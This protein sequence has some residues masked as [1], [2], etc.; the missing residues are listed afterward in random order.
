MRFYELKICDNTGAVTHAEFSSKKKGFSLSSY[1]PINLEFQINTF[2]DNLSVSLG[3][4][5]LYNID[6]S[7]FIKTQSLIGERILLRAGWDNSVFAKKLGWDNITDDVLLNMQIS[8]T[9]ADFS[10]T[11]PYLDIFFIP[12]TQA[13]N[14]PEAKQENEKE[15]EQI[16]QFV[17]E[18]KSGE[19]V[20][21]KIKATLS[22]IIDKGIK[23]VGVGSEI[24]KFINPST[25]TTVITANILSEFL[26]KINENFNDINCQFD[27]KNNCLYMYQGEDLGSVVDDE[28]ATKNAIKLKYNELI[29]QPSLISVAG[30][31][32]VETR[33]RP[34]INTG[35]RIF[36]EGNIPT[37]SSFKTGNTL[38]SNVDTKRIFK[39]G[40]Y[41]V[42]SVTH[43]GNFYGTSPQDWSSSFE[44]VP[45]KI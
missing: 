5:R 30:N 2:K 39:S 25:Q 27:A 43:K 32:T 29:S 22:E 6:V 19:L 33:M 24:L 14:I 35:S 21:D 38:V 3:F 10:G 20:F 37:T 1:A 23:V 41:K 16:E 18:I 7:F 4:I 42:I 34:D 17:S 44:C 31:L 15:T 40:Y 11:N 45:I 8:N 26:R 12:Y 9:L 36:L 13:K 28:I